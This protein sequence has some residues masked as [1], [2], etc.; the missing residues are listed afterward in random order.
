MSEEIII[1]TCDGCRFWDPEGDRLNLGL[2]RKNAPSPTSF[3]AHYRPEDGRDIIA[4]VYWPE[5]DPNEW[6]GEWEP[7]R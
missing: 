3:P 1:E 5:T 2:C 6:C 4:D 7:Q